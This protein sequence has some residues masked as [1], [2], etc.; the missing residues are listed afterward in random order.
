RLA[1][2]PHPIIRAQ[3][4]HIGHPHFSNCH[5]PYS[6]HTRRQLGTVL[7]KNSLPLQQKTPRICRDCSIVKGM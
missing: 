1:I 4:N 7:L 3:G 5:H 6:S 2:L